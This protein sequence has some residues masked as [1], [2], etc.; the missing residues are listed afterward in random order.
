MILFGQELLEFANFGR[1]TNTVFT[2][3]L[4]DFDWGR[5]QRV[6][7]AQAGFWFWTFHLL[8]N[9]LLLNMLL[10]IIMDIYTEVKGDI[11]GEAETL[12]SQAGEIWQRF[13]QVRRGHRLAMKSI[14]EALDPTPLDDDDDDNNR[15]VS[16]LT[17]AGF[18]Q[19]VPRLSE[20]QGLEIL[21][22]AHRLFEHSVRPAKCL[23]DCTKHVLHIDFVLQRVYSSVGQLMRMNEIESDLLIELPRIITS[24]KSQADNRLQEPAAQDLA[25]VLL[26]LEGLQR[27]LQRQESFLQRHSQQ[28]DSYEV[29]PSAECASEKKLAREQASVNLWSL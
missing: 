15:T 11:G 18:M 4:G 20:E 16:N 28:F 19:E 27:D 25:D 22:A 6:G 8:L 23:T 26:R 12:F 29:N 9:L 1:S 2:M 5:M 21:L 13:H 7:R 17:L 3:M 10:A 14:L 24:R